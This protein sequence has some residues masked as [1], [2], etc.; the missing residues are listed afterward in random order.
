MHEKSVEPQR[1]YRPSFAYGIL[2]ARTGIRTRVE[3]STGFHDRPLHYPDT[4]DPA[5]QIRTGDIAVTA[6]STLRCELTYYSRALYQAELRRASRSNVFL[7]LKLFDT[8]CPGGFG[9]GLASSG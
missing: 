1:L 8:R 4:T 5:S 9:S 2:G 3:S 7:V 6:R